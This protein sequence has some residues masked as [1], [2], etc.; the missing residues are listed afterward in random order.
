MHVFDLTR[1]RKPIGPRA[2]EI[3]CSVPADLAALVRQ[4]EMP[5]TWRKIWRKIQIFGDRC[6]N[7]LISLALPR[8]LE[9]LFSLG[10][11]DTAVTGSRGRTDSAENG[12]P[13][14]RVRVSP[15]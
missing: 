3:A 9:P 2:C 8:G 7:Y 10:S 15:K 12:L 1:Q 5:S 11:R 14:R 13:I 4:F 6:R